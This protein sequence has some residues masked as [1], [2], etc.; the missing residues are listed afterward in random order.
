[1]VEGGVVDGGVAAGGVVTTGGEVVGGGFGCV[2]SEVPEPSPHAAAT[3][4]KVT[5]A[6]ERF[7]RVRR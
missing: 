6:R 5:I 3:K 2:V 7:M 4:R 1:V